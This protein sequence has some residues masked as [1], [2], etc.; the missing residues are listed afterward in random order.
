M[1]SP[2]ARTAAHEALAADEAVK[3]AVAKARVAERECKRRRRGKVAV[4]T[5]RTTGR[6]Y[7]TP[8]ASQVTKP[9]TVQVPQARTNQGR[10]RCHSLCRSRR[11]WT[12][13]FHFLRMCV[14]QELAT[15]SILLFSAQCI[16]RARASASR[17]DHLQSDTDHRHCSTTLLN[18]AINASTQLFDPSSGQRPSGWDRQL[19]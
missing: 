6:G 19:V 11:K 4:A 1:A 7:A 8:A 14:Y 3:E 13:Q 15:A 2:A 16:A 9:R 5:R 10:Q 17:A 12:V 18:G